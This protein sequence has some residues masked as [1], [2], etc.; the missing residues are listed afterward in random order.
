MK[1]QK[2]LVWGKGSKNASRNM[3]PSDDRRI[4]NASSS[5]KGF[6]IVIVSLTPSWGG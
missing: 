6:G 4:W 2:D 3:E 1:K 5:R